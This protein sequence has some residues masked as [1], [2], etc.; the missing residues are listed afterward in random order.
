MLGPSKTLRGLLLAILATAAG[1][2]LLGLEWSRVLYAW[3]IRERP[4]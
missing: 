4:Y 3:R 2:G 1:A